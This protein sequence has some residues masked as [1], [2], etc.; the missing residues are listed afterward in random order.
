MVKEEYDLTS[1][2]TFLVSKHFFLSSDI[3]RW[4]QY[5]LSI[6]NR[7]IQDT[8]QSPI[9]GPKPFC[10]ILGKALCSEPG[11]TGVADAWTNTYISM[12]GAGQFR[13]T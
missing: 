11:K 13:G 4:F 12:L 2:L 1:P 3:K 10:S 5:I 9:Y 6:L 8:G 7:L